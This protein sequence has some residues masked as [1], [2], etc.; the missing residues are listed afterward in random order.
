MARWRTISNA[1]LA[2]YFAL[3]CC[4]PVPDANE[5]NVLAS[6]HPGAATRG[7]QGCGFRGLLRQPFDE[8]FGER[9]RAAQYPPTRSACGKKGGRPKLSMP[10]I[11]AAML[12]SQRPMR[13]LMYAARRTMPPRMR[14]PA[15]QEAVRVMGRRMN[16]IQNLAPATI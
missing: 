12:K 11:S 3:L 8:L 2:T 15:L 13:M 7:Q 5:I 6:C 16:E 1:S 9:H 10:S 4:L 14:L